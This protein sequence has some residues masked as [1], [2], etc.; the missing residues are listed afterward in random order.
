MKATDFDKRFAMAKIS[1]SIWNT[2]EHADP[3]RQS[4]ESTLIFQNG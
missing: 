3:G 4:R 2:Q 1:P